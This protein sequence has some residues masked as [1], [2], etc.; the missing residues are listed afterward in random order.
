VSAISMASGASCA[1]RRTDR[2][3]ISPKRSSRSHPSGVKA[4]S[5][6]NQVTYCALLRAPVRSYGLTARA[7]P[8]RM[9]LLAALSWCALILTPMRSWKNWRL[10]LTKLG[11]GT[12]SHFRTYTRRSDPAAARTLAL[13]LKE[14][15]TYITKLPKAE[16]MVPEWQAA[17]E[18]LILVARSG[19][20]TMVARIGVMR[21]LNRHVERVFDPSRKDKHLGRRKLGARS[22]TT[23][24]DQK[25]F[26]CDISH[27]RH[28][29]FL[30]NLND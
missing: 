8:Q 27:R 5:T 25:R 24:D 20:P 16:H 12:C 26:Q 19:G 1:L 30:L 23:C 7:L 10:R 22:V 2:R 9:P 15:G 3:G 4:P 13:T 18:A 14:A 29:S 17:M 21:A 11:C 28:R 6:E